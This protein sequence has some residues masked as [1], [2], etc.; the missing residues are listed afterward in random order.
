MNNKTETGKKTMNQHQIVSWSLIVALFVL[1]I[2]ILGV[3]GTFSYSESLDIIYQIG[4]Y[5]FTAVFLWWE[6]K[7]LKDFHIDMLALWIIILGK[8]IQTLILRNWGMPFSFPHI[9]SLL[10]W[11]IA[12]GLAIAMWFRRRDLPKFQWKSLGWF[13]VGTLIGIGL[14]VI[15]AIPG[16]YQVDLSITPSEFWLYLRQ[17]SVTSFFY[18]I[19]YAAVS[20]EPFF[21]GFLWGALRKVGWKEVWIWLLQAGLFTVGHI[22]YFGKYP[23]SLF[24]I[25]PFGALI[26]GLAVWKSRTI[27]TSLPI[28]GAS[29]ALGLMLSRLAAYYIK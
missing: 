18:Q 14:A 5:F 3:I 10:I 11:A 8:P 15:L 16:A 17:N 7:N 20:E 1:R 2:P 26:M 6:C 27:S 12:I 23:I 9:P 19:G 24:V 25:V 28:H 4:T 13:G 22:F 29:N 21:R